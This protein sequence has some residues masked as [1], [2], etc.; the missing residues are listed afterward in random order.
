MAWN[1]QAASCYRLKL[2]GAEPQGHF[3]TPRRRGTGVRTSST[4]HRLVEAECKSLGTS[5]FLARKKER[6]RKGGGKE[7]RREG[8]REVQTQSVMRDYV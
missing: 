2:S 5:K 6:Q 7:G 8:R 3:I 1:Q 4:R